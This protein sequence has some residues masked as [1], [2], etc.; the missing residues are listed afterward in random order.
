MNLIASVPSL[1][2][3]P[4]SLFDGVRPNLGR[5]AGPIPIVNLGGSGLARL[6]LKEWHYT[7]VTTERH[8]V[9]FAI[10]QLG[11]VANFF[12][13][14]VDRRRPDRA[15]SIETLIPLGRG[16]SFAR[17]SVDGQTSYRHGDSRVVVDYRA[18]G[19]TVGIDALVDGQRLAGR[20]D[21]QR[22]V[23][24]S[25][26]HRLD[27]GGIAYTHKAALYDVRGE[28]RYGSESLLGGEAFATLDWTRSQAARN[29]DWNWAS[30]A[31]RDTEGRKIGLNLSADVYD[32]SNGDSVENFLFLEEGPSPLGGVK[33]EMP[34]APRDMPWHIR[35]RAGDE[36][37]L[38]FE[39]FGAR[40]QDVRLGLIESRFIQPYGTYHG[41]IRDRRIEG[42]FGVVEDHHAVW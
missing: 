1:P 4:S 10:V 15:H 6:R 35:S 13:Y 33:F 29:T 41:R 27:H 31:G 26:V 11:Y 25:I 18:D 28:L 23:S 19:H 8:F 14:V 24:G 40:A 32:D 42:V 16:L 12:A 2:P 22:G 9:A 5:F 21:C 36:V 38:S 39:P 17:S 20:F 37:D 30:F 34:R 3:P 7:A